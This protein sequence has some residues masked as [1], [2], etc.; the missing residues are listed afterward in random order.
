MRNSTSKILLVAL[1][2][3]L[4]L[5]ACQSAKNP[6]EVYWEYYEACQENRF[7]DAETFLTEEAQAQRA[8][9]GVCGFTHDAIN[10]YLIE[11]GQPT[12]TFSNEPELTAQEVRAS[13]VWIDDTG[14]IASVTLLK[15]EDGWKVAESIWSN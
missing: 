10:D 1:L 11:R 4:L 5:S 15:T 13:L 12:R 8:T 7:E 9:V 6:D 2:F 14:N 3:I